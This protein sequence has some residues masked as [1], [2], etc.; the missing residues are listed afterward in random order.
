MSI[1]ICLSCGDKFNFGTVHEC[2]F[3][4]LE[5]HR[6]IW[7]SGAMWARCNNPSVQ[8]I[9]AEALWRYPNEV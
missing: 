5:L 7:Q 3:S 2:V 8:E 1:C 9:T 4:G 6:N